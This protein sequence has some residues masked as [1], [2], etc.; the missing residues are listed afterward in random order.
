MLVLIYKSL[1][2]EAEEKLFWSASTPFVKKSVPNTQLFPKS[3]CY[4]LLFITEIECSS[5]GHLI[6]WE[7]KKK[8]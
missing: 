2:I 3:V 1:H 4:S 5:M 8:S 7:N 6:R